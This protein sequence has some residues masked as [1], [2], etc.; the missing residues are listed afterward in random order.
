[1]LHVNLCRHSE[2]RR[3]SVYSGIAN[4]PNH[5]T[6]KTVKKGFAFKL[7][8]VGESGLGKS[9]LIN[10]L[11]ATDLYS[12]RIVPSSKERIES[13]TKMKTSFIEIEEN[14]IKLKLTVVDTPGFADSVD[15]TKCCMPIVKYVNRQFEDYMKK[16]SGLNRRNIV[17]SRVHCCLYFINPSGRGLRQVDIK[18]LHLLQERVNIVPVIA[19]SDTLTRRELFA[20]K[21]TVLDDLRKNRINIYDQLGFDDDEVEDVKLLIKELSSA[22][23]YAVIGSNTFFSMN[24]KAVR[25]RYYPWGVVNIE[26]P[27]HCDFVKLRTMLITFMDD[28]RDTTQDIHYE[29][30]R[31]ERLMKVEIIPT[32]FQSIEERERMV[33][34]HKSKQTTSLSEISEKD[35]ILEK[36]EKELQLMYQQIEI[37]RT[38]IKLISPK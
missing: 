15:N 3:M 32:I 33:S 26:N 31:A 6:R 17:D 12:T 8:V 38:R 29:N 25:G 24:G 9:T 11:F 16:E 18:C 23:P 7:M 36:K 4:L 13:T 35:K 5:I 27:N 30:Y 28:L 21:Q 1:M 20:L 22:I 14:G 10:S 37:M 34:L 2:T 19:K